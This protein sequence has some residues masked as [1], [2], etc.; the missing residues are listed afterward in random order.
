MQLSGKQ[1]S[2][3]RVSAGGSWVQVLVSP[4]P[5]SPRPRS[6]EPSGLAMA[7]FVIGQPAGW[8]LVN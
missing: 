5:G 7:S 2:R 4:Y 1:R 3:L 6:C 8:W